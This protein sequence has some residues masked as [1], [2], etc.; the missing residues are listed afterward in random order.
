MHS[1]DIMSR[2]VTETAAITAEVERHY[3]EIFQNNPALLDSS[4]TE[5]DIP[6]NV[7][8]IAI[9]TLYEN[10]VAAGKQITITPSLQIHRE[11]I[12]TRV[13]QEFEKNLQAQLE[14]RVADSQWYIDE[15]PAADEPEGISLP[16]RVQQAIQELASETTA[17][18]WTLQWTAWTDP[19]PEQ[20]K[21]LNELN[22]ALAAKN[23]GKLKEILQGLT[24]IGRTALY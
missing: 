2:S 21:T 15:K 23:E 7:R 17:L 16:A 20:T 11:E 6:Q 8:D 3:H 10:I 22:A 24:S 12:I 14:D 9:Q 19:Y 18:Q 1:G 5:F 4:D 13:T